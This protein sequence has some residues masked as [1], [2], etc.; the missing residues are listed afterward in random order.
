[1]VNRSSGLVRQSVVSAVGVADGDGDDAFRT[2]IIWKHGFG[3]RFWGFRN[4][5]LLAIST[6]PS[7]GNH[8]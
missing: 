2:V 3:N 1:M 4:S 7:R 8:G 5:V 6:G